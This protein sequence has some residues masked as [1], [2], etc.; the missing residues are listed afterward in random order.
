MDNNKAFML[1][2]IFRATDFQGCSPPV[3]CAPSPVWYNPVLDVS[4]S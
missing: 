4:I 1:P 3:D 2:D